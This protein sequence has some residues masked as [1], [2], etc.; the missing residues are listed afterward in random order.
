MGKKQALQGAVAEELLRSYFLGLGY[1]VVRGAKVRFASEDVT[2]IDLWLY[3]RPSPLSRERVNVD[4]KFKRRE[5][6]ALERVLWANG[7]QR[8]LGLDRSIVATTDQRDLVKEYG[9]RLGV[10]VLDGAF[11][12]R[13]K[14]SAEVDQRLSEEDLILSLCAGRDDRVARGLVRRLE[15][16]K[17]LLVTQL[18]FDACNHYLE[19]ARDF[20]S[21]ALST[22]SPGAG[23]LLYLYCSYFLVSLDYIYRS[24]AFE[25]SGRRRGILAEGFR[26]GTQGKARTESIVSLAERLIAATSP[27]R[28]SLGPQLRL[29]IFSELDSLPVDILAEFFAHQRVAGDLLPMARLFERHAYSGDLTNP[30][31]LEANLQAVVGVMLDYGGISRPQFFSLKWAGSAG[32]EAASGASGRNDLEGA[33]PRQS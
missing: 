8:S 1:F 12:A 18:D 28:R 11:W 26:H 20:I 9:K 2:D 4:A 16:G 10:L 32:A 7:L 13:L 25:D 23:R 31:G 21:D 3:A 5:A 14:G 30:D 19:E 24:F 15:Q 6:R 33:K 27:E 17:S 22:S 29:N